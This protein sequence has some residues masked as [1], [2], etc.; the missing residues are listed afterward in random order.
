GT[1]YAQ[2]P[3][4]APK[5]Q[6]N[7]YSKDGAMR[8]A[9][10]TPDTPVYAPNSYDGP[11]ADTTFDDGKGWSAAGDQVHAP[12]V[13]HPEDDDWGQPGKLVREVMGDAAR[14]RLVN[15]I[16]GHVTNGVM[17]PVLSRVF[18]Y[19][20]NVDAEVGKRVEEG[21]R[22]ALPETEPSTALGS[23]PAGSEAAKV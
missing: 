10:N 7:T 3:V 6:V 14:E 13:S 8:Y 2:L 15:N 12:Y 19:W 9:Y 4:N 11:H 16:V 5:A 17:E 18:E 1:N 23:V 22:S 21:V 20:T